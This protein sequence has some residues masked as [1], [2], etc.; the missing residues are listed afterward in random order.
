MPHNEG[1]PIEGERSKPYQLYRT[2]LDGELIERIA[3]A[4]TREELWQVHKRRPDWRYA[5]L[6]NRK[7]IWPEP[8]PCLAAA[9]KRKGK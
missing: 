3:E 7:R 9:T 5:I 4:D 6:H 8:K 2:G 1:H